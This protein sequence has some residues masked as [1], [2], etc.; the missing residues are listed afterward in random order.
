MITLKENEKIIMA[1]HKH[2]IVF[3]RHLILIVFLFLLPA[4]VIPFLPIKEAAVSLTLFFLAVYWLLVSLASFVFW[5]N[6]YF[7]MWIITSDRIMHIEQ[8][9]LFKRE[10]SEFSLDKVQ[11]VTV[12]VSGMLATFLKLGNITIHTAGEKTFFAD[13][14]PQVYKAK[15]AI[16]EQVAKIHQE[17]PPTQQNPLPAPEPLNPNL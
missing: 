5:I 9:T 2:W 4:L 12:A 8:S 14:V 11:D 16:L 3:S 10:L 6:Y 17:K 1:L 15:D 13:H 7:D